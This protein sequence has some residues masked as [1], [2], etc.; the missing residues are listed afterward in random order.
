[1]TKEDFRALGRFYYR[2]ARII[3]RTSRSK[4]L[5]AAS[6]RRFIRVGS[7]SDSNSVFVRLP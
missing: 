5:S 3:R 7:N 1:M 6:S 2:R 4:T